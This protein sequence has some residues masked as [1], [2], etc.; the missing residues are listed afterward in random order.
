MAGWKR[1]AGSA[2]LGFGLVGLVA[3]LGLSIHVNQRLATTWEVQPQVAE[4]PQRGTVAWEEARA[5]GE[6]IA[7]SRGGC[8]DCHGADLAGGTIV[9]G[10]PIGTLHGPNITMG[11]GSVVLDYTLEDWVR[12]IRHGIN[13]DG[14]TSLMPAEDLTWLSDQEIADM[15]IYL[16]DQPPVDKVMPES[17]MGPMLKVLIATNQFRLGAEIIDHTAARL[18]VPPQTADTPEFGAHLVQVCRGCHGVQLSG[19][20]IPGGP[21]DWPPA[22]NLTLHETG[23]ANWSLD[24]YTRAM[25][26]G[27]RP[28]GRQLHSAMPLGMTKEYTDVELAATWTYLKTVPLVEYGN[29]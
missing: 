7:T 10:F 6:H 17:K 28:D 1:R 16:E 5:R 23:L 29:R 25:R 12:V 13:R 18:T 24:D 4:L 20:P 9:D 27:M 22:S 19:G 21:P 11:Q 3:Y 2:F 26:E 14:T 15:V 8:V